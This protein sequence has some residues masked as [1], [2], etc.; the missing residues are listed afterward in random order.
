MAGGTPRR[1]GDDMS[2]TVEEAFKETA[3]YVLKTV[4]NCGWR[5]ATEDGLDE[6]TCTKVLIIALR[7]VADGLEAD[8]ALDMTKVVQDSFDFHRMDTDLR[9]PA[10]RKRR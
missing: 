3:R 2:K 9:F 8:D 4:Q 10:R 1:D 6:Q 7:C 5:L